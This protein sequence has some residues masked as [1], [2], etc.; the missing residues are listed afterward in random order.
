MRPKGAPE[1]VEIIDIDAIDPGLDTGTP[2]DVTKFS[3]FQT[4]HKPGMSSVDSTAHIER[5]TRN[6]LG[7]FLGAPSDIEMGPEL[8]HALR[9]SMVAEELGASPQL[10]P[11]A[12]EFEPAAKRKRQATEGT[13]GPINKREKGGSPDVEE[14]EGKWVCPI[15]E[16]TS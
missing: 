14:V 4:Q 10:N 12:T 9:G 11:D 7:E 1:N 16:A 3:P 15:L 2:L 13:G 8:A 6:A 5:Q